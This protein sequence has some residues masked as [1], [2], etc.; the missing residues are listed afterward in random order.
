M[1]KVYNCKACNN[2]EQLSDLIWGDKG[3]FYLICAKCYAKEN[4]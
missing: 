2:Q 3:N 1:S 4:N